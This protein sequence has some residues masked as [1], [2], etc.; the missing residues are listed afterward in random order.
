MFKAKYP[1][2][3]AQNMKRFFSVKVVI[4]LLSVL[5]F[6]FFLFC[7]PSNLFQKP[8]STVLYSAEGNLLS[9]IIADDGQWRFPAEDT[10]PSR[11]RA[12]ILEYEDQHFFDHSGVYLPSVF[13]ALKQNLSEKKII[14]GASTITM[15]VVRLSRNNPR[16]T[17]LEKITEMI[18]ALRLEWTYS[19]AEIL[20]LY[21]SN[22][23]F[24]GNVVGLEAAAW[25]YYGR[26][27]SE[28]SWA[29]AATLAVLPNAP[30]LIFPGKNQEELLSKR[31]RL[32]RSLCASGHLDEKTLELSLLE[33][34]PGKPHPL[35]HKSP[36]LLQRF[37]RENGKGHSYTTT[38]KE[39]LQLHCDDILNNYLAP[40]HASHVHNAA[41]L[42]VEVKTG[43]VLA[44]VGNAHDEMNRYGN[45]VDIIA[46][47]RSTGS[48]L[49]PFLYAAMLSDGII[50]PDA[51][52]P[53][54]PV[55]LDGFAPQ[56]YS[57]TFDGAVPAS[58]ALSRSLNIPA[59]LML[60][61]YGYPR[62]Y[63]TLQKLG[64]SH[65]NFPAEH[66]GLSLI[67]GGGEASLWEITH[68]YAGM[69]RTL[70]EY[71][72]TNGHYQSDAYSMRYL[73]SHDEKKRSEE[74]YPV[75]NAGSIW[76]TYEALLK[77]NKPESE[78]GWEA[79]SSYSPVAWKTGTS[80]GNRDAWAV[81]T[82]PEYVVGV[83]MGN[84]DGQGR[85]ELTGVGAAAPLLF[86][87]FS[88]LGNRTWF[89][90]PFD[91]LEKMEVCTL[92]GMRAGP[93]CAAIDTIHQPRSGNASPMCAYHM[94][95]YTDAGKKHRLNKD[96]AG[97][98]E[99]VLQSWF[100]LPPVQ[101]YFYKIRHPEYVPL[102]P[103]AETCADDEEKM[104]GLIYPRG[105]TRLFVPKNIAGEFEKI[106]LKAV[107][108]EADE[109]L[110]WHLD[111]QYLGETSGIHQMEI[112][113]SAGQH[114][115]TLIDQKG[116]SLIRSLNVVEK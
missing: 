106:V 85:P 35:P 45:M 37:I 92:S 8:R 110:Y 89:S 58:A 66:Y 15:Q 68:A 57:E 33:P 88:V 97:N 41:V 98:E 116:R 111:G 30:A 29:E 25:R 55:Q 63:H 17:V 36:H 27:A 76:S 83:W 96:C 104:I 108:K 61:E 18:R 13:R 102:P 44:Y 48:I 42:I 72:N 12:A 93:F 103:Y 21:A 4:G 64:F 105:D 31:N 52:V 20:A 60:R 53:D 24:G 11:F 80:F 112:H 87:I 50:L 107:H 75:L 3:S 40:F 16:R 100:V 5:L 7:I 39:D 82:S 43:N 1:V 114:T 6:I 34:L 67:L 47:P 65:F 10:V 22:A 81:G 38:V 78:L 115:L 101:E 74:Y 91:D 32:L 46:A 77:V 113:P 49:K 109:V 9:A 84:A 51:L 71:K 70:N 79:Y 86:Q 54:I 99:M 69:S 14:S 28:L 94:Q 90:P 73:E 19:K 95:I 2:H 26:S 59:V 62:F 23:P 56:N